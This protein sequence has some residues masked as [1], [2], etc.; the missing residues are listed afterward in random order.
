MDPMTTRLRATSPRPNGEASGLDL[1]STLRTMGDDDLA[2]LLGERPDLATPAPSSITALASRASAPS[3]IRRA[4]A[5]LTL[6]ELTVAQTLA[7]LGAGEQPVPT[8][9]V[10]TAVGFP[11][12]SLLERLARL[13]LIAAH[14]DGW[15]LLPAVAAELQDR[16][17]GLGPSLRALD[18]DPK[19]GWPTTPAAVKAALRGAP[20]AAITMLDALTWGPG[21][22]SY[23][24]GNAAVAWL[25]E[26]RL[27]HPASADRIVLPREVALALRG[28]R[29]A[30]QIA[31]E[32]PLEE[33]AERADSLIA[34][35]SAR[36]G[37]EVLHQVDAV[38]SALTAQPAQVLRSGGLSARDLRSMATALDVETDRA[39]FVVEMAA[40]VPLIGEH[41]DDAGS[42]WAPTRTAAL[43]RSEPI[44]HRWAHLVRGWLRSSRVPWLI[45]TRTDKGAL[46][47]PLSPDLD[48]A[49]AP[50]LRADVLAALS[51]WPEGS[52]P[53]A[54]AVTAHL[55][56]YRPRTS[57]PAATVEAVLKEMSVLG[58]TGAGALSKAG[59][60]LLDQPH[61]PDQGGHAVQLN[62][63]DAVAAAFAAA[64][65]P[66]VNEVIIQGDLTGIVPGRPGP[67]LA[68]L[69]SQATQ[70]ESRGSA[71]AVRFTPRSV[72][73]ALDAGHDP[74]Q[75]VADLEG[76][77]A[78]G[79]P[80]PLRYLVGDVARKHGQVRV[81]SAG[82][83]I[84]SGDE[85]VIAAVLS[86][87]RLDFL[88]LRAITP[89]VLLS[90]LRPADL[91]EH[92]AAR[93]HSA[94]IEGADGRTHAPA[95]T[96]IVAT[97]TLPEPAAVRT[98]ADDPD[99]LAAL[100]ARIRA[101]DAQRPSG[102]HRST[103]TAGDPANVVQ[104]LQL[105]AERGEPVTLMVAG[106]SGA[107]AQQRLVPVSVSGGRVR[108]R[109]TRTEADLT[110]AVHRIAE[111]RLDEP[112]G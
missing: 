51:R 37:E 47:A 104:T 15:S 28:D 64:L 96:Q 62:Q 93:G 43:Q 65:P 52:A 36:V 46:R 16:A 13:V 94:V 18:L 49:W 68:G 23:V 82:A 63:A 11:P 81:A 106:A 111:V 70:V 6:P 41:L 10:G 92:L 17:L 108:A 3:S 59:R 90:P 107:P 79:V 86:D 78:T 20:D 101:K 66:I 45:G 48:R 5:M 83:V 35:E 56:W 102:Q 21:V 19:E 14:P 60:A 95:S 22:G 69:L 103:V 105:A 1:V 39:A 55:G 44:E 89:N 50:G 100:I 76:L 34:A 88:G 61:L 110:I 33:S 9:K 8:A 71:M 109:D 77:S 99:A 57:P 98:L 73:N 27:V 30:A 91:V 72:Q 87:R 40:L 80:Q 54:A 75:L 42:L 2:T 26:A 67:E 29:I 97:R 74:D 7:V 31:V 84:H 4:V 112:P 58:L 25:I 38:T 32:A 85:G 53:S 24:Q 12:E